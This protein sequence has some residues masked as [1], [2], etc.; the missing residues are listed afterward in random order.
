MT[1]A[2][3]LRRVLAALASAGAVA[4]ASCGGRGG[5]EPALVVTPDPIDFGRVPWMETPTKKV[6]LRNRSSRDLLLKDPK[7]DCACFFLAT[8]MPSVR[9]TPGR[10]VE[11][12]IAF[13]TTKGAPG[14]FK[15]TFTVICDDP[16]FPKLDVPISGT[17][18]DFRQVSPRD[19]A[20]GDV[21]VAGPPVEKKF[22]VRGGSGYVA[23][24]VEAT[25][26]DPALALALKDVPEGTDVLVRTKP[27]LKPGAIGAQVRL[28]L[29]VYGVDGVRHRYDD[30]VSVRGT[31]R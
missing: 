16:A 6:V 9:L 17:V 7:F 24:A 28:V 13:A 4:L 12:S 8:P 22:E 20:L 30:V 2:R 27:G 10:S 3:S 29:E 26:H 23:R 19:L 5:P 11:V 14:P 15:K 1:A 31:V 25:T 21:P 18:T